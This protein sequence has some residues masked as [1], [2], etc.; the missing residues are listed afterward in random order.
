MKKMVKWSL[1]VDCLYKFNH[2][3]KDVF[4]H[5]N[6]IKNTQNIFANISL[7]HSVF[8]ILLTLAFKNPVYESL[9]T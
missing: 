3:L 4:E 9:I 5:Y 7:K 8:N 2:I 6:C 1:P